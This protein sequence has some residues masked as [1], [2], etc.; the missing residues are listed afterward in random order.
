MLMSFETYLSAAT[1]GVRCCRV[2]PLAPV[3]VLAPEAPADEAAAATAGRA[4]A[5][6]AAALAKFIRAAGCFADVE[7]IPAFTAATLLAPFGP[8]FPRA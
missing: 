3:G 8:A 5:G 7:A 1:A 4:T 6:F 2:A